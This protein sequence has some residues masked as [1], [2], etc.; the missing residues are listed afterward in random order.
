M[1]EYLGINKIIT[2][3]D[4]D[5]NEVEN[6]LHNVTIWTIEITLCTII[7]VFVIVIFNITIYRMFYFIN[8]TKKMNQMK[9]RMS[10]IMNLNSNQTVKNTDTAHSGS[11]NNCDQQES[12]RCVESKKQHNQQQQQ[13][14]DTN[15]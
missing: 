7:Q 12:V 15:T 13:K 3:S 4:N 11:G 10:S 14:Y 2:N 8:Q 6:D 1:F 9:Q 5:S